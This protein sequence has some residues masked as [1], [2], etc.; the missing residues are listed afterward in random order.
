VKSLDRLERPVTGRRWLS[1]YRQDDTT[2]EKNVLRD[3]NN[4]NDALFASSLCC[5]L[6]PTN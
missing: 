5:L 1:R 4:N 2:T 6:W 3:I